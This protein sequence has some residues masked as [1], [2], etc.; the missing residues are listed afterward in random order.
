MVLVVKLVGDDNPGLRNR[1]D[2][3]INYLSGIYK[4]R[5]GSISRRLRPSTYIYVGTRPTVS[6]E[7]KCA[8]LCR[9]TW[10]SFYRENN[11]TVWAG[12]AVR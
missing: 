3:P 2:I 10:D 9:G 4:T 1:H 6:S 7:H 12:V 8:C 11:L 5:S